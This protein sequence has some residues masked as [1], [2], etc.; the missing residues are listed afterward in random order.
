M[1]TVRDTPRQVI[2]ILIRKAEIHPE[3]YILE[4]SAG[5][6]AILEV[7]AEHRNHST[8]KVDAVELNDEKFRHLNGKLKNDLLD[9]KFLM[10]HAFHS[11]FL[12]FAKQQSVAPYNRIIAAPPFKDN[13]D[14]A[15]I[16]AMYGLLIS[17]GILVSLTTPYWLTNNEEHQ[18][19]F[20]KWLEDKDYSITMLPDM[21]FVEKGR[22]VPTAIIKI[23]K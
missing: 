18:V 21:T 20:R 14:L 1:K 8:M 3:C 17:D 12:L 15:H 13:I 7:L 6:G 16:R 2:D 5:G 4:P 11:D 19:K 22:T 9:K 23:Y 10:Y